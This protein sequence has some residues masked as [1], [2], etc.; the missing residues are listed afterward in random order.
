MMLMKNFTSEIKTVNDLAIVFYTDEDGNDW[1]ESQKLFSLSTLK[2]M[3][4][5]VG[6]IVASAW[7][8]SMLA[9]DG[10]SVTE[11]TKTSVPEDF[12]DNG[13]RWLFDGKKIKQFEYSPEEIQQQAANKK[14]ELLETAKSKI[15]VAQTKLTLGRKLSETELSTLNGWLDY[16]DALEAVDLRGAPDIAWPEVSEY[17]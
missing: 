5:K 7:D 1:Y 14:N 6:N 9:P 15:I 13:K 2:I 16:I 12:F 17:V 3:F 8:V 10:L 4:D 11:I